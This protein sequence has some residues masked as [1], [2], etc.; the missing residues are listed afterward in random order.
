MD[1]LK[2]IFENRIAGSSGSGGNG[3]SGGDFAHT[4]SF[5]VDG[6][7]YAKVSVV[8]GAVI[9]ELMPVVESGRLFK[10]WKDGNDIVTFPYTPQTDKTF[11]AYITDDLISVLYDYYSV[12]RTEY[13]YIFIVRDISSHYT[14]IYFAKE[15]SASAGGVT[16]GYDKMHGK[17]DYDYTFVDDPSNVSSVVEYIMAEVAAVSYRSG[18]ESVGDDSRDFVYSNLPVSAISMIPAT[19]YQI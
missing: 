1:F 17:K 15:Y 14:R 13:P 11:I 3:E 16:L 2:N 12:D 9:P 10:H 4:I 18:T 6:N 7:D 19:V 5:T 8:D